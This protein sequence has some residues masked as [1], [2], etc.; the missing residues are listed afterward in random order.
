MSYYS[1]FIVTQREDID[2]FDNFGKAKIL[3]V[4]SSFFVRIANFQVDTSSGILNVE[5][6]E[7]MRF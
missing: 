3:L 2:T 7:K 1:Q 4:F 6:V 5:K